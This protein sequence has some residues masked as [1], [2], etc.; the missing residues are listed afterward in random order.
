MSTATIPVIIDTDPGIDDASAILWVL[1]NPQIDVKALSITCGNV[2]L[3]LCEKNALRLLEATNRSDIP[4]YLGA[5]RPIIKP[6]INATFAHG[7]D[8]MGDCGLPLPTTMA[9]TGIAS[10]EM[11]RIARESETPITV[12]AIGPLTNVALAILLDSEFK[13]NVK[14]ILFMGGAVQ[15]AGNM[16][17]T[18]SFN[19]VADPEAA[20]I[21]YNSGIPI[22]Q[23]GLD[24]CEKFTITFDDIAD[25]A[26]SN[27]TVSR[28]LTKMF[29][30]R[31]KQVGNQAPSKFYKV[32]NNGIALNDLATTAYLINK[33]WFQTEF[34]PIDI[35]INGLCAGQT[36]VDFR[37]HWKKDPNAWFAYDVNAQEA[38]TKWKN[39]II[40]FYS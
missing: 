13:N 16:T 5:Y 21:V 8:G 20:K 23:I 3:H 17:P 4:V 37:N 10:V 38:I 15:V 29:E 14:E 36:I 31:T 32:R 30:F 25:I 7:E 24:C 11:A 9:A 2:G 40:S 28:T 35:E 27:S 1:A 39:D 34:L 6:L 18:A 12:L 33:D 22:V 26:K 19:V